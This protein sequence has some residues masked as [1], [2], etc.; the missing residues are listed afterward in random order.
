ME[1]PILVFYIGIKNLTNE[2]TVKLIH[3]QKAIIDKSYTFSNNII[4]PDSNRLEN[5]VECVNPVILEKEDYVIVKEKIDKMLE[6]A[7]TFFDNLK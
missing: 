7:N 4:M 2:E 5:K 3:N 6:K 1:K